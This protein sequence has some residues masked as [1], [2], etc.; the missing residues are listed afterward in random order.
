MGISE[1]IGV[2]ALVLGL[3]LVVLGN[4]AGG[5][6]A[7]TALALVVAFAVAAAGAAA[8]AGRLSTDVDGWRPADPEPGYS[9]P[10]PGDE[11]D[12]W[13][14]QDRRERIRERVV[15][16]L[17]DATDCSRSE[18]SARV[19][20]GAWTDDAL[21]AAYLDDEPLDLPA[22]ARLRG[23]FREESLEGQARRRT[24]AALRRLREGNAP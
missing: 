20:N 9:V 14:E 1:R 6:G 16:S 23:W 13:P 10:V 18:A 5:S 3:A 22:Y 4:P 17:V 8:A 21:A 12:A 19:D 15:V 11:Y 7:A 2:G 24:I